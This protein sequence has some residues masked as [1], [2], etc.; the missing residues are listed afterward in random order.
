MKVYALS[1]VRLLCHPAR[2][3]P[4]QANLAGSLRFGRLQA[5]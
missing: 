5:Y 3:I 2:G 4:L 1:N